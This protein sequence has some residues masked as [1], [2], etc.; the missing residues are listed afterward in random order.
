[1]N[2]SLCDPVDA[3]WISPFYPSPM[4][5][6]G[7]DIS[8]YKDVDPIFG[9]LADFDDL[10]HESHRLGLKVVI[11][12]V[13]NHSSDLHPWFLESK[14]SRNNAKRDWYVWRNPKD[15]GTPPNNWQ[16][17]FGGGSSWTLDKTTRQYYLHSFLKEQPDLNWRNEELR[18]E[19]LD[20]LRFWLD[21]GVDGFRVDASY[22]CMKDPDLKDNPPNFNWKAGQDPACVLHE[23]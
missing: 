18:N 10:L 5:D 11:D 23:M 14:S 8:N 12:Y 21:R 9:T 7:Y 1:M 4:K 3:F 17:R 19:M 6:F 16:S 20:V 22:Y 2:Y 13:P 15:D